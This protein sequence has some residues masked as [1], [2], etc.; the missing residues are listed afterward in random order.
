ML[1]ALPAAPACSL[2]STRSMHLVLPVPLLLLPLL[3]LL[4]R[5][6]LMWHRQAVAH[7]YL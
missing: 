7:H 4:V 3:V 2:P 5:P 1:G 6:L